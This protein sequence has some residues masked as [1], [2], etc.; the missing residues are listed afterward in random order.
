MHAYLWLQ[1]QSP[2]FPADAIQHGC[3]DRIP[4]AP[5]KGESHPRRKSHISAGS[6]HPISPV[7]HVVV[8][9][10]VALGGPFSARAIPKART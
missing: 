10:L 7:C 2:T 1:A 8:Q 9:A 5:K 3:E 6:S 4:I